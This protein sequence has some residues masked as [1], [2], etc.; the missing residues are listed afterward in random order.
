MKHQ[1]GG[2]IFSKLF[3]K[4][5]NVSDLY[6]M[7]SYSNITGI[8]GVDTKSK[9]TGYLFYLFIAL[10]AVLIILVLI[11][12]TITPIFR[13]Q[14]GDK[15]VI[16]VPGS[17]DSNRYWDTPAKV[18]MIRDPFPSKSFEWSMGLT[19][20]VDDPTR[21]TGAPRIL[22]YRGGELVENYVYD[23]SHTILNMFQ[24][25][26]LPNL[27][28]YLDK[29]NNDLYVSTISKNMDPGASISLETVLVPNFPV[30]KSVRLGVGV[31]TRFLE[32]YVNGQLY[33]S[34]TYVNSSI[35]NNVGDI[36]PAITSVLEN[37]ARVRYLRL[38]QR[39]LSAFEFREDGTP[40]ALEDKAVPD[41][42]VA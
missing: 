35:Q 16:G 37:V 29:L 30:R 8:D 42:C 3:G 7:D 34:R 2:A 31:H 5:N 19:I 41:T 20:S 26:K 15:G 12:F 24:A 22:F 13:F 17:D 18:Q 4:K 1:K 27:V 23:S 32:V 40:Q 9:I 33:K 21:N 38:W 6:S 28:I 10:I 36:Y 39:S 11:H 25:N 14:P